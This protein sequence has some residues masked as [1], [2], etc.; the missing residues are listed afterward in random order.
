MLRRM[1]DICFK[2]GLSGSEGY[3]SD[4]KDVDVSLAYTGYLLWKKSDQLK[5]C[6]SEWPYA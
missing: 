2:Y 4:S 3:P 1:V 6:S 5:E